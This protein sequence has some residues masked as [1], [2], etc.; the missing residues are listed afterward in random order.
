[1]GANGKLKGRFIQPRPWGLG[2]SQPRP[3]P[4]GL[5]WV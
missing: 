1:M 4:H 3:R 5:G 2:D